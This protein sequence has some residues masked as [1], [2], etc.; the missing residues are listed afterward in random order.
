MAGIQ[1]ARRSLL[2]DADVVREDKEPME[3]RREG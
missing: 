1:R 2:S 3:V